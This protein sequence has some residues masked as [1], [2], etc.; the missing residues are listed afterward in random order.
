MRHNL[1][2]IKL[3]VIALSSDLAK[4]GKTWHSV[5]I[6]AE[7][8]ITLMGVEPVNF[9]SIHYSIKRWSVNVLRKKALKICDG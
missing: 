7:H 4:Y 5:I 6:A 9:V 3:N 2:M 1:K 8:N